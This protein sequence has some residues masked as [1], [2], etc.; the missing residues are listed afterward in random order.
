ME[1]GRAKMVAGLF[2][3]WGRAAASI[4]SYKDIWA[5]ILLS[6]RHEDIKEYYTVRHDAAGRKLVSGLRH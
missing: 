4:G 5:H 3:G 2:S 6:C 1:K